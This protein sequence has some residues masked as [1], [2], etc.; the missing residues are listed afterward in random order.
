[1]ARVGRGQPLAPAVLDLPPCRS[2]CSSLARV[3]GA[4]SSQLEWSVGCGGAVPQPAHA[5]VSPLHPSSA[6]QCG[7]RLAHP[8]APAGHQD[9]CFSPSVSTTS[10]RC[11]GSPPRGRRGRRSLASR[12]PPVRHP[13]PTGWEG[14]TTPGC[15]M[16]SAPSR[17][18]SEKRK[19]SQ[20]P[21]LLLSDG[22][23]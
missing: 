23:R 22:K 7:S 20:P 2:A 16:R 10:S 6:S 17:N 12:W 4:A 13:C 5:P 21:W 19:D 3:W 15:A 8:S 14:S 11:P 1:M 9:G 18:R